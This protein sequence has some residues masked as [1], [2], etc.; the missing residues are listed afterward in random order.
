[1][2]EIRINIADAGTI[3]WKIDGV[4]Q[5][6]FSGD[7]KPGA[8]TGYDTFNYCDVGTQEFYFDDLAFDDAAWCGEGRIVALIPNGSGVSTQW[9]PSTG[10][11]WSCVDEV[12]PN[13]TDY[14]SGSA[15]S[16]LDM[17]DLSA[18]SP[19]GVTIISVYPEARVLKDSAGTEQVYLPVRSGSTTTDGTAVTVPTASYSRIVGDR[20]TVNPTTGVAWTEAD[21]ASLQAGVKYV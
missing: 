9:T 15:S 16:L 4:T 1:L 6:S 20:R 10:A 5:P 13:T 21:L 3:E 2:I 19:T 7:T 18:F 8:D 11:N 14:V 17:Y 12:P